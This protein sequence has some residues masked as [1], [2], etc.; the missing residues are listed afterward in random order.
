MEVMRTRMKYQNKNIHFIFGGRIDERYIEKE[1]VLYVIYSF[2]PG[3][4]GFKKMCCVRIT[5]MKAV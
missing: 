3:E 2:Y 1:Y 5:I 4:G